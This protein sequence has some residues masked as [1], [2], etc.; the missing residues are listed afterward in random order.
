[1]I[2]RT[3]TE[4]YLRHFNHL[5]GVLC[6][7]WQSAFC[8]TSKQLDLNKLKE[9]IRSRGI[10]N[11][12]NAIKIEEPFIVKEKPHFKTLTWVNDY[13]VEENSE[14]I[15]CEYIELYK[16]AL[17]E[18]EDNL[19]ELNKKSDKIAYA[20]IILRDFNKSYHH[21][22]TINNSE[23]NN[24]CKEFFEF[25]LN[26][27][28]IAKDDSISVDNDQSTALPNYDLSARLINHFHFIDKFFMF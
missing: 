9:Q 12:E 11:H 6:L 3:L 1:M 22:H 7:C 14:N 16:R 20:N 4:L 24:K 5:H 19:F 28:F 17:K 27:Q 8:Y 10:Y 25:V 2:A 26:R 23:Q 21:N 13:I 18:V 15:F